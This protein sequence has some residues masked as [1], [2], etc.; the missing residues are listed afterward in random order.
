MA[1]SS[2]A[3]IGSVEVLKHPAKPPPA[4]PQPRPSSVQYYYQALA[5]SQGQGSHHFT[6]QLLHPERMEGVHVGVGV[7]GRGGCLSSPG[8]CTLLPLTHSGWWWGRG[9]PISCFPSRELPSRGSPRA[10]VRGREVLLR[11]HGILLQAGASLET[12]PPASVLGSQLNCLYRCCRG[13]QDVRIQLGAPYHQGTLAQRSRREA[14]AE[15]LPR[16][17]MSLIGLAAASRQPSW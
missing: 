6:R 3:D 13:F 7:E 4:A 1:L 5:H 16:T 10:P 17:S 15:T 2:Q 9:N 14:L 11:I 12:E 8:E